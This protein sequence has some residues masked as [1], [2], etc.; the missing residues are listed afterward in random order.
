MRLW[1]EALHAIG[2]AT[3]FQLNSPKLYCMTFAQTMYISVKPNHNPNP[4]LYPEY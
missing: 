2:N 3:K 1:D 4:N